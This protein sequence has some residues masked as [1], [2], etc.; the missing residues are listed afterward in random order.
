[1][2]N[3]NFNNSLIKLKKLINGNDILN[4]FKIIFNRNKE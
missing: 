4:N 3:N 2:E 1:M